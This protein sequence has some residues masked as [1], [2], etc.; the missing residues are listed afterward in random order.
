MMSSVGVALLLLLS[1]VLLASAAPSQGMGK[2]KCHNKDGSVL[3]APHTDGEDHGDHDH[4]R[5]R[6]R[7]LDHPGT[8]ASTYLVRTGTCN[9]WTS[10]IR[11]YTA[12][13]GN[14]GGTYVRVFSDGSTTA[15][16]DAKLKRNGL[17][18]KNASVMAHL[19]VGNCFDHNENG[20]PDFDENGVRTSSS[21]PLWKHP[22]STSGEKKEMHFQF[23]T[24]KDG[25]SDA[26]S[27]TP[28][29][30]TREANSI[31]LHES[32]VGAIVPR[33]SK[34]AMGAKKLCCDILWG[35][36][37]VRSA[38]AQVGGRGMSG[39]AASAVVGVAA[40]AIGRAR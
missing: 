4:H 22:D 39:Y 14:Q 17:L 40:W 20:H 5:S 21:G 27:C 36:D 9:T 35:K 11:N 29:E 34:D 26:M 10:L 25:V 30:V 28:Y 6:A 15:Q 3:E 23:T 38:G 13:A 31:V 19:H 1:P 24:D 16:I 33:G 32:D 7:R 18:L 12:S 2:A 8:E 37:E